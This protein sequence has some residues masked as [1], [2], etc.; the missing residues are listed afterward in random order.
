M[1][2]LTA[3]AKI[4]TPTKISVLGDVSNPFISSAVYS[5][6]VLFAKMMSMQQP[7]DIHIIAL[8]S[9][10]GMNYSLRMHALKRIIGK[11]Y[12]AELA[13]RRTKSR[14]CKQ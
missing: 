6:C 5:V 13:D 7:I 3:I 10:L 4:C 8:K 2:R 9:Y 1:H 12:V 11:I 14:Y